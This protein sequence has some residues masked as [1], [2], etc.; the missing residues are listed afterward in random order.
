MIIDC[1]HCR[2]RLGFFLFTVKTVMARQA[3]AQVPS[4]VA[5]VLSNVSHVSNKITHWAT[6]FMYVLWE[7][8]S[9]YKIPIL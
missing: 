7:I 8:N 9:Y 6:Y 2:D 1:S 3:L 4:N 5:Q